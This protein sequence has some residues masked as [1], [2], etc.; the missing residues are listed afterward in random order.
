MFHNS[1]DD[2]MQLVD[3][4]CLR[5]HNETKIECLEQEIKTKNAQIADLQNK[6]NAYLQPSERIVKWFCEFFEESPRPTGRFGRI[7]Y[8]IS[9]L[10]PNQFDYV[11]EC[12]RFGLINFCDS[13][14]YH[15]SEKGFIL[16]D[17]QKSKTEAD[18]YC[19]Y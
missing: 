2:Y 4:K 16:L 10:K 19:H 11:L 15:I 9:D 13:R 8:W 17:E 1:F 7:F 3:L 18:N 12:Y 5:F 14:G 6:L